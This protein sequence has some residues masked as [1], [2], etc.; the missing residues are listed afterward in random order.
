M[1]ILSSRDG[2]KHFIVNRSTVLCIIFGH[3]FIELAVL[4]FDVFNWSAKY[5]LSHWS[6]ELYWSIFSRNSQIPSVTF[7]YRSSVFNVSNTV[8]SD[9]DRGFSAFP[10]YQLFSR[11]D[12]FRFGLCMITFGQKKLVA[13]LSGG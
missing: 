10:L 9:K 5:R 6:T 2:I 12:F 8:F 1:K 4:K 11:K 13:C 3:V 7:C